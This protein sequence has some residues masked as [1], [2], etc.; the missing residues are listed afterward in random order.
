MKT[1]DVEQGSSEWMS[2]REG[3]I[4][5]TKLGK[6]YA[7]SRHIDTFYD[8]DKPLLGFY[9]ILAER[10][11]V[12]TGD[13][14]DEDGFGSSRERGKDLEGEA[15]ERA[16]EEL[17]LR[18]QRG[19]VWQSSKDE[20]HIT[21]P[22]GFTKDLETAVEIK[23]LS[24]AR[25][26]MAILTN[27]PPKDYFAEYINYFLVNEKLKK[28]FVCLYDPRFIPKQLQFKSWELKREDLSFE[29]A[30]FEDIKDDA[31][32]QFAEITKKI[33]EEFA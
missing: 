15:I 24:S 26:L 33:M 23:C 29:I 7:K 32:R 20:N 31:E 19:G 8:T 3:K 18:F 9:E 30:R 13:E 12:G 27:Q 21:S 14:G 10:L 4:T 1:I 2:F 22:D 25:H 5:G 11:A 6:I 16:E 28:L 17:G